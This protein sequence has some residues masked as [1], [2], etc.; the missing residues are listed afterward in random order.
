VSFGA[1]ISGGNVIVTMSAGK[2]IPAGSRQGILR[3]KKDGVEIAHAAV[4]VF[5][6]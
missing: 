1:A 5:I 2:G 4:Y 6:K 3:I